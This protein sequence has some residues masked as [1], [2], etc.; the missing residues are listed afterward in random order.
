LNAPFELFPSDF[1]DN[2][3]AKYEAGFQGKADFFES[4]L[5]PGQPG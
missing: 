4:P 1:S 5:C 3:F 2:G